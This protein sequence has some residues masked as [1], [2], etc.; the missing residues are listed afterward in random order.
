VRRDT[1]A[2][3]RSHAKINLYLDVLDRRPDGY[4]NIETIFQTID[5]CDELA[6]EDAPGDIV[7]TCSD[8]ALDCGEGNLVA[9]AARAL[10]ERTGVTRGARLRLTKRIPVAAGLAGGSGD[11]AAAL[12][13]L[14]D[15]W[16]LGLGPDALV[17][18]GAGLGADV[19]YCLRGGTMAA[20]GRGDVMWPVGPVP[21]A[22][23]VLLHPGIP[24]STAA[25]YQSDLLEHSEEAPL[26]GSTPSFRN[27]IAALEGGD[28]PAAVFNRMETAVFPVHGELAGFRDRLLAAGCRAAAMSGSGP[29]LFGVCGTA[30]AARDVRAAF[31]DVCATVARPV[32]RGVERIPG[33]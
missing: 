10:R 12:V 30:R 4:H 24:V 32:G 7:L 19:P 14:N 3:Y 21:E 8:P 11:A 17:E 6:A 20:T 13:A 22:W 31:D 25:V 5:L 15:V 23:Y 27:A 18:L 28:L 26:D 9:R 29:T 2:L 33:P 16:E 1:V